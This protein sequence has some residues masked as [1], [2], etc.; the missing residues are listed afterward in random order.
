MLAILFA[1]I[2]SLFGIVGA[3]VALAIVVC[4]TFWSFWSA[5]SDALACTGAVLCKDIHVLAAAAKLAERAAIPV[6]CIYEIEDAQPN[7]FAIGPNPQSAVVVL[8]SALSAELT[9]A[10]LAAVV[11][12]E[13]AHI[14]NRDTLVCTIAATFVNAIASLALVLGLIGLAVRRHGGVAIIFLALLAPII[15][16]ILKFALSRSAEYRADRDA[17]AL[18]GHPRYLISALQKLDLVSRS[19]QSNS[20]ALQPAFASLY[21]VDPLPQSWLGMLFSAHPPL[22]RRIARLEAMGNDFEGKRS[23]Q[24]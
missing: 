6:P 18:C 2:G 8:T 13:L 17:A 1:L 15:A 14:R 22:A 21:I 23:T 16:L 24:T 19:V 5:A 12:H 11:A 10:E 20:A 4:L 9:E 3:A 7:A